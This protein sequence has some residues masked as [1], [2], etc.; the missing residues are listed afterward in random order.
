M[1]KFIGI[2][3]AFN[4][5]L[6]NTS[7]YIKENKTLLLIDCGETVFARI[8]EMN[9][10]SDVENVYV[11][12]THMHSDHVG[13]LASLIDYLYWNK[14]IVPNLILPNGDEESEV[15]EETFR[16]YLTILGISE[17]HYET[18]YADMM[19]DVLT[20]LKTINYLTVKHSPRLVSYAIELI[21]ENKKII[22]VGDNNDVS[23][24]NKISYTMDENTFVYTD[25]STGENEVHIS[26]D[27][28][29][30]IFDEEKRKNIYC[31]HFDNYEVI[32][33]AKGLGF[34]VAGRELSKAELLKQIAS[35]KI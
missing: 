12:I 31:T 9:L 15:A 20:G 7:A 25:C 16:K 30:E 34:K 2:G 8:Q 1:L 28:L 18:T 22:Y 17:D 4:Y 32:N 23:Y 14:N 5:E 11:A 35:R 29:A 10:L 6:G 21:F 13:S 26:L 24:M 33:K 19:E 3:S 27:A